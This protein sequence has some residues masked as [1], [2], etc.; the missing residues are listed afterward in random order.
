MDGGDHR[1]TNTYEPYAEEI[2]VRL[3]QVHQQKK[4]LPTRRKGRAN[5]N[6]SDVGT[7][8]NMGL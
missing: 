2:L 8:Q 3:Y 5:K 7:D 1:L 4:F 6:N